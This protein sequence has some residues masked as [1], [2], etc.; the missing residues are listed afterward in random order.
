MSKTKDGENII[1]SKDGFIKRASKI[2]EILAENE[3]SR[4]VEAVLED[5]TRFKV[6]LSLR[7]C[8][9]YL[10]EICGQNTYG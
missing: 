2:N 9:R 8:M 6:P 10:K 7:Q 5:G 3:H 4:E 1:L